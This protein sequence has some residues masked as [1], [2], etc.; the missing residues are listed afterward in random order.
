MIVNNL[1]RC[2]MLRILGIKSNNPAPVRAPEVPTIGAAASAVTAVALAKIPRP[3]PP[4]PGSTT[5]PLPPDPVVKG[6]RPLPPDPVKPGS[7]LVDR[8]TTGSDESAIGSIPD[9]VVARG[10]KAQEAR[11]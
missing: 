7:S 11:R 1:K 6:A 4:L 5:R 3:L 2:C 10:L 8:A 9:S